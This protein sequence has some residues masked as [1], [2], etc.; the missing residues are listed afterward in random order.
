ML[1]AVPRDIL[2]ELQSLHAVDADGSLEATFQLGLC[3]VAGFGVQRDG[4]QAVD[5][6]KRAAEG[7][8]SKARLALPRIAGAFGVALSPETRQLVISW[9]IEASRNGPGIAWMELER[10]G[11]EQRILGPSELLRTATNIAKSPHD[12]GLLHAVK[13]GDE[14]AVRKLSTHGS[15]P[16]QFGETPLHCATL[17]PKSVGLPIAEIL[18]KGGANIYQPTSRQYQL[19]RDDFILEAMPE[20]TTP[21]EWAI[22]NDRV[23]FVRLFLEFS[24]S[25][26]LP[27]EVYGSTTTPLAYAAR[28]QSIKCLKYLCNE[29]GRSNA[30]INTF[31]K[32]GF[33]A[34]YYA[35]RPDLLDRVL[36]YVPE[37][38]DG[39]TRSDISPVVA[40]EESIINMLVASGSDMKVSSAGHFN[41]LHLITAFGEP[42][43]LE[44]VLNIKGS[45]LLVNQESQYGW[46]PLVDAIFWRR[47]D[48]FKLL[49]EH[50]ASPKDIWPK[51]K[52]H[53]IHTCCLLP[54][55]SSAL[56]F[57]ETLLHEHP[58]CLH[59]RDTWNRTPLHFA[60]I[61]GKLK[62]IDLYLSKGAKLLVFDIHRITPLGLAVEARSM[63][64]VRRLRDEH[65]SRNLPLL[66]FKT[67]S[68][69]PRYF[70]VF[71]FLLQPGGKSP[72]YVRNSRVPSP[73]PGCADH[74]FSGPSLNVLDDLLSHYKYRVSFGIN[75]IESIVHSP[76]K[77]ESGIREA[78]QMANW[79]AVDMI[80]KS[81]KFTVDLRHLLKI[82]FDQR[83]LGSG[84]FASEDARKKM[85]KYLWQEQE[86]EYQALYKTRQ[87]SLMRFLWR[88]HYRMYGTMEQE[89]YQ[90]VNQWLFDNRYLWHK[91]MFP[92]L[93]LWVHTRLPVTLILSIFV[94]CLLC[95]L[96]VCLAII[97]A[98]P[99]T[100]Y[101]TRNKG[102]TG[103]MVFCVSQALI[104]CWLHSLISSVKT[105]T[106]LFFPQM[107]R[108]L[109]IAYCASQKTLKLRSWQMR[110]VQSVLCLAVPALGVFNIWIL[111]PENANIVRFHPKYSLAKGVAWD[112]RVLPPWRQNIL[113]HFFRLCDVLLAWSV[114]A[115]V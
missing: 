83:I 44:A 15:F 54:N 34:F 100:Q 30:D 85:V 107:L 35:V 96:L 23:S 114:I 113:G 14:E 48:S 56:F 79:D 16:G 40:R 5:L 55:T 73:Y 92:D 74:P 2:I 65:D 93:D 99:A 47:K 80:L 59:A 64:G 104:R 94:G 6:V 1:L 58:S 82:A 69:S 27:S 101:G 13:L 3:H 102:R 38:R 75:F 4:Q 43:T 37:E 98:D 106:L 60:A 19:S 31:D 111:N 105:S 18:L 28:H 77:H 26:D 109:T 21:L 7:G 12:S 68:L 84:H 115:Y 33:S 22:I 61:F 53:A 46:T 78:V 36:R 67:S 8:L 45:D 20:H 11:F 103:V 95:P 81:G 90:R 51:T 29:H 9:L 89:Q 52:R 108:G 87:T 10:L 57:A 91:P 63:R 86:E 110:L 42:S 112:A 17:L 97:T 70:S 72:T 76:Y 88:Y 71:H 32:Y 62:L 49:L 24:E 39:P 50:H 41:C 25:S 66:G